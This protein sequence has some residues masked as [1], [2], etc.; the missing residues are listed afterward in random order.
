MGLAI[1]LRAG[2]R[3]I[4]ASMISCC[5]RSRIQV[6]GLGR[7]AS[8]QAYKTSASIGSFAK[9]KSKTLLRHTNATTE[10]ERHVRQNHFE[11]QSVKIS[12]EG[13]VLGDLV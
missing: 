8:S 12:K 10:C 7:Q 6:A 1:T 13:R 4:L 2:F 3:F 9:N 5:C 11:D